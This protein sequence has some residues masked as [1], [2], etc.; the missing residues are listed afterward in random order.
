MT[1]EVLAIVQAL[2]TL[3]AVALLA[4][5]LKV[6]R[7]SVRLHKEA[8]ESA[9]RTAHIE[10]ATAE[11]LA[12]AMD[13]TRRA[14]ELAARPVLRLAW[15]VRGRVPDVGH[16]PVVFAASVTNVGHGTAVIESVRL[17]THG[18]V[19]VAYSSAEGDELERLKAE[20]DREVFRSITG[21]DLATLEAH[22]TLAQLTD[23]T[24][25]LEVGGK[26]D[27]LRVQLYAHQAEL[28]EHGLE[29]VSVQVS[30]RSLAGTRF[31]T[32]EQFADLR[33]HQ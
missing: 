8:L 28:L 25:A 11:A 20:F 31:E 4:Y 13:A 24:R 18:V 6:G 3:A 21:T 27:V 9:S 2:A 12:A 29:A 17:L 16:T 23:G 26:L 7:D 22:L 10:R 1:L 30:Y 14:Q 19:R 33:E 5:A 15:D 32:A